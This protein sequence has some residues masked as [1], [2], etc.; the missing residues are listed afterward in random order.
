MYIIDLELNYPFPILKKSGAKYANFITWM[1][2]STDIYG[3][4]TDQE[5]NFGGSPERCRLC[6]IATESRLH[7]LTGCSATVHLISK[8]IDSI[9]GIS[10]GKFLKFTQLPDSER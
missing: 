8:F 6:D 7:L 1:T 3:D 5:R 9:R 2:A 10:F 4:K